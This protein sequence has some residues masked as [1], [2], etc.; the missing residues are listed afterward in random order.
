[1]RFCSLGSGSTG[2][3][4]LIEARDG[5]RTTRVLLDCGFSQ[6]ELASRLMRAGAAVEQI[7]AIFVTH[8]HGDHV[9][10]A[11]ALSRRHRIPVWMSRGTWHAIRR[12]S[13]PVESLF[14]EEP[15]TSDGDLVFFARDSEP[16][17]FAGLQLTPYTVPHDAN[18]PLQATFSDGLSRLGVLTDAGS[19]TAHM[20]AHLR[21]C[22]A[23]M[24]ECNHDIDMLAASAYPASLRARISGRLGHLSNA[25]AAEILASVSHGGLRRVVAAHLSE[26]N[27][28]AALARGALAHVIGAHPEEIF[29][30]DPKLGT[31]WFDLR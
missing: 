28:T 9:G 13:E 31:G 21:G 7:D 4:S 30:A 24:L 29:V 8:E 27:N 25:S 11:L 3:A 10:C 12:L 14:A 19:S 6:R 16:I 26:K 5:Q 2:N 1:M 18:E 20:L 22:D 23:L 17:D 15:A